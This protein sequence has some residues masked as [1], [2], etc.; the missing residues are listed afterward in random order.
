M[1][2]DWQMNIIYRLQEKLNF[3]Y[4]NSEKRDLTRWRCV[5]DNLITKKNSG[6]L[7]LWF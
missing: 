2:N 5:G 4:V 1:I 6:W 3:E 7:R